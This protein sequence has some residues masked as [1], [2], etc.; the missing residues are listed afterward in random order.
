[1]HLNR[2]Q[3]FSMLIRYICFP[4]C[5]N[6][7]QFHEQIQHHDWGFWLVFPIKQRGEK[8]V[9]FCATP[10]HKVTAFKAKIL[11]GAATNPISR[12][13]QAL[14][15][16]A[17]ADPYL[18]PPAVHSDIPVGQNIHKLHQPG[19]HRVQ[20]VSCKG[21]GPAGQICPS[22]RNHIGIYSPAVKT[23]QKAPKSD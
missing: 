19:H 6:F 15:A 20:P 14:A 7:V 12:E 23:Q 4:D 13:C 21:N 8:T 3:K 10:R 9:K 5:I 2:L 1:M 11:C 22:L 18:E 16:S 17:A